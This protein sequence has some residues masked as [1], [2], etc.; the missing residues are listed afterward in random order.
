M[1][2][3]NNKYELFEYFKSVR[4]PN[5]CRETVF[6]KKFE[7]IYEDFKLSMFYTLD[8][9]FKERLYL[10]FTDDYKLSS[11]KCKCGNKKRF[12][13]FNDGYYPFCSHT[14][15]ANDE[16]VKK[17]TSETFKNFSQEYKT[18]INKN[19][20]E[21]LKEYYRN[22][23]NE[24]KKIISERC[25]NNFHSSKEKEERTIKK[26]I[27]TKSK[28]SDD[29]KILHHNNYSNGQLKRSKEDLIIS[30]L[31]RKETRSKWSKE[32]YNEFINNCKIAASN[33]EKINKILNTKKKNGTT[34]TSSLE[35]RFE[36]YLEK[37]NIGFIK[38]YKSELYPFACDFYIV[39]KKIYVEIQGNWTH[40]KHPFNPNN[41]DDV[42]LLNSWK[43]KNTE[44]YKKAIKDW[45]KRDPHKREVAY[46]N[47]LNFLEIFCNNFDE[48]IQEFTQ[49]Y[50]RI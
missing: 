17:R 37:N 36:E 47:N 5:L 15:A 40:G 29:E 11:L 48:L 6:Q 10:F 34:S 8:L 13:S 22:P 16:D 33:P 28:W 19:R 2:E 43:N 25:Y 45:T 9:S 12:H 38:Q 49:Y 3:Y 27:E 35:K 41:K 1:N 24:V 7:K 31:K 18:K 30:N 42:E 23:S 14:C 44:Y 21:K 4:N 32:K 20:S 46:S 50:E 39:D 26:I